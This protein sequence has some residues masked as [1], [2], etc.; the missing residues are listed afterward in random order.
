ML[1][2]KK[3][4]VLNDPDFAG[5][6]VNLL[7]QAVEAVGVSYLNLPEAAREKEII[8]A[9]IAAYDVS[10]SIFKFSEETDKLI[11]NEIIP[12]FVQGLVN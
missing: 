8:E 2:T 4:L 12:E 6:L 11:K 3:L 1:D 10:D 7:F 9:C 5:K